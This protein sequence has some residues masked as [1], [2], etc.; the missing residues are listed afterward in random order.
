MNATA[1]RATPQNPP[2]GGADGKE[3]TGSMRSDLL[4]ALSEAQAVANDPGPAALGRDDDRPDMAYELAPLLVIAQ[5]DRQIFELT[6]Q[7]SKALRRNRVLE[8]CLRE[9][10]RLKDGND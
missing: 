2:A 3:N 9:T 1:R 8:D 4:L 5:R 10:Y 7:L 6:I